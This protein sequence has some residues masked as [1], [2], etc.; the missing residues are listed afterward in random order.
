[1]DILITDSDGT[2]TLQ[3]S[4]RL[5]TLTAPELEGPLKQAVEKYSEVVMDC[6]QLDYVSSAGVRVLLIG[7]KAADASGHSLAL[8]NVSGDVREVFEMTGFSDI[9][10]IR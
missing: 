6:A 5:D 1:M 2:R 3:V 9:L 10:T 4:G 8:S 7:Q